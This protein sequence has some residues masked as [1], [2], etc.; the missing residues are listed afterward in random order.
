[1]NKKQKMLLFGAAAVVLCMVALVVVLILRDQQTVQAVNDAQARADSLAVA[2]DRL[3]L[4]NEFNQLSA[5]FNQYEGQQMYLKND[6]LVQKYNQARM[7]VEG[8]IQELNAEK[9]KNVRTSKDLAATRAKIKQLEGEVATLKGIV[10][11]YLEEIKRLGEENA[12]LKQE[13]QQEKQRNEQLSTQVTQAT[14][15]NAELTQTVKLAKKLNITGV[16]FHAYNK[17]GK[18]EKNITKAKSLGVQFT[19]SPNN[20]A[21]PGMK[22]FYMRILTPEGSLL[23]GGGSFTMD[24]QTIQ[25]TAQRSVEYANEELPVAIY[26]DVNTTLTPG[27]YTVEVF[28]DGYRLASRHFTMTK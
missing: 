12:G 6:S 24:G 10:R 15:S 8:L 14:A 22:T 19:V 20:T 17:K 11:H 21:A 9:A 25:A 4:T 28:C 5:E 3:V 2:N 13:I 26:W 18:T 27:D 16:S 7:K 1:M 23:S